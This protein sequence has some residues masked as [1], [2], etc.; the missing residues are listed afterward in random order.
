VNLRRSER[1]ARQKDKTKIAESDLKQPQAKR[2]KKE[3]EEEEKN[4]FPILELPAELSAKILSYMGE[5]ELSVCLQSFALY[6]VHAEL[7]KD[8]RIK[9]MDFFMRGEKARME[10]VRHV[11]KHEWTSFRCVSDRLRIL[12]N[13]CEFGD[14]KIW[15]LNGCNASNFRTIIEL[16][17]G[18]RCTKEL[19]I[20]GMDLAC[21]RSLTDQSLRELMS[22]KKTVKIYE[23][24]ERIRASGLFAVWEDL[25]DG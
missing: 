24:C 17:K 14:L 18:I 20:G 4:S 5:E 25:L 10:S 11:R 2:M 6:K 16:C 15:V 13:I 23:S 3:K 19:T 1:I 21:S 12:S 22:N 8:K 9:I 7:N